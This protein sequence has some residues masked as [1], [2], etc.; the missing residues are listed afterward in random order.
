MQET[1]SEIKQSATKSEKSV[2]ISDVVRKFLL[3]HLFVGIIGFTLFFLFAV[4]IDFF[5]SLFDPQ[6]NVS[7]DFFT[8]LIGLGGFLITFGF[9]YLENFKK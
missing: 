3:N 2:K 6:K 7:I 8:L 1:N 9:S 4:F 5:L